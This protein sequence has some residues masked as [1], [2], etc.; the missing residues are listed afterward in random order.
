[1]GILPMSQGLGGVRDG[2]CYL[3]I[4]IIKFF[5]FFIFSV[6]WKGGEAYPIIMLPSNKHNFILKFFIFYF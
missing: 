2:A 5:W 4:N 3:Q 6:K 1:M